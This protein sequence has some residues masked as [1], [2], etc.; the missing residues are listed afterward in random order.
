MDV[1]LAD[2]PEIEA[3]EEVPQEVIEPTQE[4]EGNALVACL[5]SDGVPLTFPIPK[6]SSTEIRV[7]DPDTA[8]LEMAAAAAPQ[9]PATTAAG[10]SAVM[11]GQPIDTIVGSVRQANPPPRGGQA[12]A[13]VPA[14]AASRGGRG[15]LR[16][17][18]IVFD[19]SSS[20]AA[21]APSYQLPTTSSLARGA[22][23]AQSARRSGGLFRGPRRGVGRRGAP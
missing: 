17:E 20:P 15:R 1:R 14:A 8:L 11:V 2:E 13:P 9:P 3:A 6:F 4:A 5:G 21:P 16:R 18:P 7:E 12:A 19:L 22:R 23:G 10:P